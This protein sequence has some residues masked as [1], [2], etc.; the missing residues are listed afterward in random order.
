MQRTEKYDTE[1]SGTMIS[2]VNSPL[3]NLVRGTHKRILHFKSP[4]VVLFFQ[5]TFGTYG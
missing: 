3:Q 2:G 1:E 5:G 4:H